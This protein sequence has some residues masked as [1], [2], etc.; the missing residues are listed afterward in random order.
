MPVLVPTNVE[1]HGDQQDE[2][3]RHGTAANGKIHAQHAV[4]DADDGGRAEYGLRKRASAPAE[5]Y[6]AEHDARNDSELR[7]NAGRKRGRV[8]PRRVENSS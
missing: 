6:A 7:P 5:A 1:N 2:A 4:V 3:H 8:K